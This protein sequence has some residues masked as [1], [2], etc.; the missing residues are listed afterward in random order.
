M[1]ELA[2][3]QLEFI[4]RKGELSRLEGSLEE[5]VAGRGST[6]LLSGEAGIG[7]TRLVEEFRKKAGAKNAKVLSGSASAEMANPFLVFSMA[8]ESIMDRPLFIEEM[9]TSFTEVFAVNRTGL[10]VAEAVPEGEALDA[11]IFAGMLS[12]VQDFVRDSFDS[13]GEKRSGLGRLEYG[14]MKILIEHGSRLFLTAVFR[15]TEHPGMKDLL[16]RTL[17]DIEERYGDVLES[18]SGSVSEVAPVKE[19]ILRLA[20]TKFLVKRDLE[21]LKLENERIRIADH[22]LETLE[23]ATETQPLLLILEDLHWAEESSLFVLNYLARNVRDKRILILGTQRPDEDR[24]LQ[25][26]VASM[27]DE[28]IP[29]TEIKVEKLGGEDVGSLIDEMFTPNRFPP[30]FVDRLVGRCG[31]NP[32]F[33]IEMLKQMLDEG[34]VARKDGDFVLEREDYVI[35]TTV[36]DVVHQRLE[37][38][39]PEAIALA[40]YASCIGRVFGRD[41]A[42]SL[43]SLTDAPSALGSLKSTGIVTADN[44][45]AEFT[46][47]IFQEV[48]YTGI[49]D[50]WRS[51]YHKSIGEHFESTYGTSPDDVLYELARHFSR[52]NEHQ[53][54]FDYCLKAGA[55]AENAF[56]AEQAIGFY[57]TAVRL[58]P[59]IRS[60][61]GDNQVEILERLGGLNSLVGRYD[62]AIESYEKAGATAQDAATKASMLRRV[63]WT[64]GKMGEFDRSLEVLAQAKEMAEEGSVEYGRILSSEGYPHYRKGE[65]DKGLERYDAALKIFEKGGGQQKDIGNVLRSIGTIL[66]NKGEF[67]S[68]LEYF[69]KSLSVMEGIDEHHGVAASLN[70]I[71]NVYDYQGKLEN[72]LEYYQRVLGIEEKIGHRDGIAIALNNIG[73]MHLA[74][75]HP[76]KALEFFERSLGI[77]ENIGDKPGIAMS[78]TCIGLVHQSRGEWDKVLELYQRGLILN[79]S[80]GD[81]HGTALSLNNI[82][83]V[84]RYKG[85]VDRALEYHN[86]S[87]RI[88]SEIGD[89]WL[90]VHNRCGLAEAYLDLKD[91]DKVLENV[92]M[93]TKTASEIGAK[94]EEAWTHRILG[95]LH[96]ETGD[97]VEAEAEF[98]KARTILE[99]FGERIELAGLHYEYGLMHKAKGDSARAEEFL[100][101]ALADFEGMG[102]DMWAD[103]CRKVLEVL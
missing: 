57:E 40:E 29:L 7:K 34:T 19:E 6:V 16:R 18:W 4:G 77:R 41:V 3:Q 100:R 51:V 9:H 33:V 99:E 80:V 66:L 28:G 74:M 21:G 55:K 72:A 62:M 89:K 92:D 87:L 39:E 42:F 70:N 35:P 91:T 8:M 102:L 97:W 11:D 54:A 26:T 94:A 25:D 67:D 53:K 45:N 61:A 84:Y 93:A 76:D 86:K 48:I 79:E 1:E 59:N 63:G 90:E 17:D 64:Y 47:A 22:V 95:M 20:G 96:R 101:K 14:D 37:A 71:G 73:N 27:K 31:G 52:S 32:F 12:A 68:A 103:K 2:F 46:H 81:K 49:G 88:C 60:G 58:I 23:T 85:E 82:G 36:E 44:G 43:E 13:S 15:G 78:L 30:E 75:G 5:A 98:G 50:R 56:A 24:V 65:F 10:L 83:Q 38:L 69:H